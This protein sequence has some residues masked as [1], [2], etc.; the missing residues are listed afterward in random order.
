MRR[1]F[2]SL[3]VLQCIF[4]YNAKAQLYVGPTIGSE[5]SKIYFFD[6]YRYDYFKPRPSFGFSGGLMASMR[7]HK[8]YV[9]NA[10]LLYSWRTKDIGP[11]GQDPEFKF[12]SKMQYIELPIFY[13]LEF[14][15][16]KGDLSGR[17]G[18]IKTYNWF[19]GAGPIVS[20]WLS[21]K[22]TMQS[23]NLKEIKIDHIDY[24]TIFGA[25]PLSGGQP[26]T[27]NKEYVS[28]ANRFQ[29]GINFTGGLSFEPVGLHKIVTFVQ[30]NLMQTF[31]AKSDVSLPTLD[32][33][34]LRARNH[35]IR[36]SVAY[37]FDTK[38]ET[39]KKGKSTK[40]KA[41]QK[42]RR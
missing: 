19:V 13:A 3:I 41:M 34:V 18:K 30:L 26:I 15:S 8:N 17:G 31:L 37:L 21:G 33:D 16:L 2:F 20:Y 36:F 35:S 32:I 9:L 5:V 22:S 27:S 10:Q 29:F 25:D 28:E 12:T 1:I 23:S 42:K 4:F 7:I 24:T 14:K 40:G 39:A 11:G 6:N 38:I